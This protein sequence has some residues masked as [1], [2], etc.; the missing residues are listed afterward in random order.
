MKLEDHSVTQLRNLLSSV[1]KDVSIPKY[2]KMDKKTLIKAMRSHPRLSF[3]E[4]NEET[5]AVTIEVL[6][7]VDE[8]PKLMKPTRPFKGKKTHKMPDGKKMT[9]KVHSAKSKPIKE[10]KE[11]KE[12][13]N[14]ATGLKSKYDPKKGPKK[15]RSEKQKA[16]DK[17]LGEA[18]KARAKRSVT[19]KMN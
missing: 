11:P 8:P 6:A 7:K 2:Y 3:K 13:V 10:K 19:P 9:G 15:P 4:N 5:D 1:K 14:K 17:K 12:F 16:N 18:A